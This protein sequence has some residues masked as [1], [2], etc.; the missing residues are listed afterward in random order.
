MASMVT[1]RSL[2]PVTTGSRDCS[3][4]QRGSFSRRLGTGNHDA[5]SGRPATTEARTCVATTNRTDSTAASICTP[6]NES[7]RRV[8][9]SG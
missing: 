7:M 4:S 6:A 8:V 5:R 2:S 3:R 1:G 9:S